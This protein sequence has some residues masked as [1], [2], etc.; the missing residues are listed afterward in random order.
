MNPASTKEGIGMK[1]WWA[2]WSDEGFPFAAEAED[3][4]EAYRL[5]LQ[6]MERQ[7]T[8]PLGAHAVSPVVPEDAS[9]DMGIG[10]CVLL[11]DGRYLDTVGDGSAHDEDGGE[12]WSILEGVGEPGEDGEYEIYRL[13]G[14]AEK[15]C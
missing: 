9:Q 12:W 3:E 14:W 11:E 8:S 15:W 7:G 5:A 4:A 1:K 13:V 10:P 2:V 6:E